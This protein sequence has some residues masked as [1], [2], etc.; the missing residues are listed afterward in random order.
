[1]MTPWCLRGAPPFTAGFKNSNST[2]SQIRSL[3]QNFFARVVNSDTHLVAADIE[4]HNLPDGD[5]GAAAF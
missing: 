1:M 4:T 3:S 5:A 2:R